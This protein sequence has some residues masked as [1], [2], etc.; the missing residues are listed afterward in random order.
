VTYE[1]SLNGVNVWKTLRRSREKGAKVLLIPGFWTGDQSLYP[2]AWRL[3]AAGHRVFFA[4]IWLN[5]GCPRATVESLSDALRKLYESDHE[6][7]VV[8]GHSLGGIFARELARRSPAMIERIILMGSAIRNP[9][10]STNPFVLTWYVVSRPGHREGGGCVDSLADLCG[11]HYLEPPGL[12]ETIIYSKRDEVVNWTSCLE[13]G[14]EVESFEVN[15]SHCLLP[16]NPE[17]VRIILKRLKREPAAIAA[18][19]P[20]AARS[21]VRSAARYR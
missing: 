18:T 17:V 2:L 8:I 13:S 11:T 4:G 19:P 15:A 12:P 7:L 16:Y 20:A 1:F 5:N 9:L 21:T 10:A 3:R 6:P 14:P